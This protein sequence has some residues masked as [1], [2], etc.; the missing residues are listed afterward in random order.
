MKRQLNEEIIEDDGHEIV[1]RADFGFA[2]SVN[3]NES[4]KD[5]SMMFAELANGAINVT[6]IKHIIKCGVVSKDGQAVKDKDVFAQEVINRHGLQQA[7]QLCYLLLSHI[8]LGEKKSSKIRYEERAKALTDNFIGL[9]STSLKRV[10]CLWVMTL[11][12]STSAA[13]LITKLM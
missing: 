13:C 4:K 12:I 1:F 6:D 8:L 2:Y 3:E 11:T 9:K 10:L 5:I 7:Q